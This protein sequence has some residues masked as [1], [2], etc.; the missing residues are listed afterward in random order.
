MLFL[1]LFLA[2]LGN[3]SIDPADVGENDSSVI[4]EERICATLKGRQICDF[5]AINEVGEEVAL[6]D[7]YGEPIV[8]DLSAMWC[9][10]C[11]IA[12]NAMQQKADILPGV[13]FLTV[14]IEN[15]SGE[16]PQAYDVDSW[17]TSRGIISEPVWGS[18]RDILSSDPLDMENHLFLSGWPTFYFIDSEGNLQEYMRGYDEA[19]IMEKAAALD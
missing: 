3:K 6:S 13:T 17:K 18:S 2:C 12:G 8:L 7:L 10:P 4:V 11:V 14:L 9:G 1:S 15:T 5:P 16:P 19:T